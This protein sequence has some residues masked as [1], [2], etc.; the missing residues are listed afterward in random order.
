MNKKIREVGLHRLFCLSTFLLAALAPSQAHASDQAQQ[1]NVRVGW[2][3]ASYSGTNVES[4]FSVM[5]VTNIEYE[6]FSTLRSSFLLNAILAI[7]FSSSQIRYAGF[8]AGQRFYFSGNGLSLN[9][10][11]GDFSYEAQSDLRYFAGWNLN[12]AQVMVVEFGKVLQANSG[13]I[14]AQGHGGLS[15]QLGKSSSLQLLVNTGY[16]YGI[17]SVSVS[18][19]VI[20]AYLGIAWLL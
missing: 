11:E 5:P 10:S 1:L 7:D 4:S 6:I 2:L 15:Y 20:G 9:R 12:F 18:G 17:S 3:K 19:I 8:G 13:L 16:G 14:E